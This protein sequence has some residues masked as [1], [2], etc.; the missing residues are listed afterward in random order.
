[1]R[2][3]TLLEVGVDASGASV[4]RRVHCEAPLLVRAETGEHGLTLWLVGGA[5]GPLGG[6][7][8]SLDLRVDSGA[9]V[10]VRSVAAQAVHPS[11]HGTASTLRTSITVGDEAVVD[12]APEPTLSIVG[13]VHTTSLRVDAVASARV[14]LAESLVLGR[15][16][17]AGGTI[18]LA[19]RVHVNGEV[20]LH[21][22]STF[23]PG[24]WSSPGANGP[25][26][27]F[28][29][30]LHLGPDAPTTTSSSVSPTCVHAVLSIAPGV[31]LATTATTTA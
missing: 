20:V 5:A 18:T 12:W 9:H 23:G 8:L 28:R 10:R 3:A 31:A 14:R 17:E 1:V 21:T 7:E 16:H 29:S 22:A 6:D 15:H 24:V 11:P 4:L 13:S 26:R 19:Q 27:T 2:A 30:E 25:F